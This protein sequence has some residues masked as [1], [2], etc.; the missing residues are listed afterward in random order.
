MPTLINVIIFAIIVI[1]CLIIYIIR[2]S[3]LIELAYV[4][5]PSVVIIIFV[6]VVVIVILIAIVMI[7]KALF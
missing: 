5:T 7:T 2:G 3:P 6:I 1:I 4:E